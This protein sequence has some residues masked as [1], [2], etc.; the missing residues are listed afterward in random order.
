MS[1]YTTTAGNVCDKLDPGVNGSLHYHQMSVVLCRRHFLFL[2]CK[3]A[4]RYNTYHLSWHIHK[5]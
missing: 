2:S 1:E 4:Q 5:N 3:V